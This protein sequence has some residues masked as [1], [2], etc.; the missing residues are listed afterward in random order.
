MISKN[1]ALIGSLLAAAVGTAAAP[2]L[3]GVSISYGLFYQ[4][5]SRQTTATS[6]DPYLWSVSL[7]WFGLAGDLTAATVLT[8]A[9]VSTPYAMY[10]AEPGGLLYE[11]GFTSEAELISAFP[12]GVYTF[13][14]S[15]GSLGNS[16][17]TATMPD[18]VQWPSAVPLFD[19][20]TLAALP[21]V[22]ASTPLNLGFNSFTTVADQG[23]TFL[24]IVQNSNGAQPVA[25]SLLMSDTS[26]VVPA[27]T[28]LPNT[29]YTAALYFSSLALDTSISFGGSRSFSGA[30]YVT[31]F[32]LFTGTPPV[33]CSLADVA[34]DSLDTTRNPNGSI[35]A[36]DLDAFIAGF[37]AEDA[38]ISD[39]ASDSLD[40]TYNPNGSVGAED[41]DAFIAS[42]IAGC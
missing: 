17:G 32:P 5:N 24:L 37:I 41:L 35:G 19:A 31:T 4:I 30:N 36:E 9:P 27:G 10:E 40:T 6:A 28:L 18:P 1:T 13:D 3:A 26:F 11:I 23:D 8:P 33:A 29:Q 12:T 15:G 25:Q 2:A 34:S 14:I 42:F 7:R 39:V 22:D 20:A 21:F 16:T 38:A